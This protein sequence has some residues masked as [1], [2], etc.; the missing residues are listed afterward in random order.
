VNQGDHVISGDADVCFTTIL[1]SCVAFCLHDPVARIGGMNHFLLPEPPSDDALA[2]RRYGAYLAEV[3]INDLTNG[4]ARRDRLQAKIFGG[5]RMMNSLKD[6]GGANAAFASS[7]LANEGIRIVSKS[8]G[9]TSAR[10]V[11]FWPE[12]SRAFQRLVAGAEP[13]NLIL[14]SAPSVGDAELF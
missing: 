6:I 2:A 4:G 11:E 13:E 3:L 10:R 9:G 1:G 7:F 5:A 14:R 12:S 8:L